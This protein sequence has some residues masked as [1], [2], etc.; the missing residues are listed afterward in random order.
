MNFKARK[1]NAAFWAGIASVIVAAIYQIL[2][3]CGI[4]P[5]ISQSD[6]INLISLVLTILA[7][8]G[9]VVDPTTK[10]IKDSK[11]VMA[12]G[13]MDYDGEAAAMEDESEEEA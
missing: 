6:V 1:D 7:G 8:L 12:R 13:K 10:G 5:A 11:R 9:V 4:T 2:G 3:M